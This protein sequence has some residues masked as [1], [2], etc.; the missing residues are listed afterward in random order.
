M[1]FCSNC[2][3]EVEEGVKFCPFC[4]QAINGENAKQ[5]NK[6]DFSDKLQG[7][8]DTADTTDEFSPEDIAQNK[9]MAVVSY[10]GILVLIPIFGAPKSKFARFHANQGLVLFIADIAYSIVQSIITKVFYAI[11][12]SLGSIVSSILGLVWILFLV[13]VIIGIVNAANG[14]AKELPVIGKITILK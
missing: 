6:T 14:R 10:L 9:G 8:N 4:G 13:L 3:T 12:W 11:S 1:A 2:G 5:A 7:L